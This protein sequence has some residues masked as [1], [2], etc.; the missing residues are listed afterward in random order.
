MLTELLYIILAELYY[1]NGIMLL[2]DLCY[3]MLYFK[4]NHYLA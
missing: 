1:M 3:I 4:E 2:A